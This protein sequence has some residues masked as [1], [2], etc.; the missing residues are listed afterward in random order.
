MCPWVYLWTVPLSA[1]AGAEI[2]QA[3]GEI[4]RLRSNVGSHMRKK[5]GPILLLCKPLFHFHFGSF[6]FFLFI[7]LQF[8][9][10]V[11]NTAIELWSSST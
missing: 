9:K 3:E 7:F 10:G 4:K 6:S 11:N 5:K 1:L 2:T 8:K